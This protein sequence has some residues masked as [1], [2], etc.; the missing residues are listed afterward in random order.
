M[1]GGPGYPGSCCLG[2]HTT[3]ISPFHHEGY[4]RL[5]NKM[6]TD[7]GGPSGGGGAPPGC[8]R[9]CCSRSWKVLFTTQSPYLKSPCHRIL[10]RIY[11]HSLSF[12]PE[13]QL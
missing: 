4:I 7:G 10:R 8:L 1:D 11:T 13:A 3:H 5:H 12:P 2:L 9:M 6:V